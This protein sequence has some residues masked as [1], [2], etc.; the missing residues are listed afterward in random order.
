MSFLGD[1][2][3]KVRTM[4]PSDIRRL[5]RG[6]FGKRKNR[7]DEYRDGYRNE[8]R[9]E[10]RD[11][12]PYERPGEDRDENREDRRNEGREEIDNS[13]RNNESSGDGESADDSDAGGAGS[14][15]ADGTAT[16]ENDVVSEETSAGDARTDTGRDGTGAGEGRADSLSD[17]TRAG[18]R[19]RVSLLP[20]PKA[21]ANRPRRTARKRYT[22]VEPEPAVLLN[23][24]AVWE[25]LSKGEPPAEALGAA[26]TGLKTNHVP[27][28]S[29]IVTTYE[30]VIRYFEKTVI[31]ILS[32]TFGGY[33]LIVADTSMS[34]AV[35]DALERYRDKRIRYYSVPGNRGD[36]SLINDAA[37]LA[38]GDYVCTVDCGDLLTKDAL[39]EV[40]LAIMRTKAEILYTDE[41]MCDSQ[42]K[43]FEQPYYKPDFNK[44]YLLAT[45]YT[46]HL[47]VM[48]RELF[49]ALRMRDAF[50]GAL[51]YDLMLRAP[52]SEVC[53]VPHILYHVSN[54]S[55]EAKKAGREQ[56]ADISAGKAA[57]EDYLR[58][59][60]IRATVRYSSRRGIY[61]IDY[62]PSIF[63]CR[64]DVGVLGGRVLSRT[65]KVIG[66]MIDIKGQTVYEGWDEAEGGPRN[67]ALTVQDAY[68]VDVRCMQVRSELRSLYASIFGFPYAGSRARAAQDP[69][70]LQ[71]LRKKSIIFC[72]TVRG[73]GYLIVWDPSFISVV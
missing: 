64:S 8:Y 70:E 12:A 47:L 62:E 5:W 17:G 21:L 68:A 38:D 20:V 16:G 15:A 71:E 50:D 49:L 32:Q 53:H 72:R 42:G 45:N 57:L 30:P 69:Q 43:R 56:D 25:R 24:K 18:G 67:L 34:T 9:D 46:K 44:D 4:H 23:Q 6:L 1:M 40:F 51:T 35:R 73:M 55:S 29:V 3:K 66:G 26:F 22:Y 28:F 63:A 60:D 33:E 61:R 10:A 52:K 27:K 19:R 11:E 48:R 14:S 39:Y 7:R 31:S 54:A 13:D 58:I 65:H 2:G 37:H 36:A 59:R 41:D